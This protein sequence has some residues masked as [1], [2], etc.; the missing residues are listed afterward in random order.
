M[1]PV[2]SLLYQC[3]PSTLCVSSNNTVSLAYYTYLSWTIQISNGAGQSVASF[4]SPDN[5]GANG[6]WKAASTQDFSQVFDVVE[7]KFTLEGE[8]G[9][10]FIEYIVCNN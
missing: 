8:G 10:A 3:F 4:S 7:L 2:L 5:I 9:V 1:F 6:L